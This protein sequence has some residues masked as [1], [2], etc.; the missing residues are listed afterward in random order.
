MNCPLLHVYVE[1]RMGMQKA[2]ENI[3]KI[4]IYSGIT[5]S[6]FTWLLKGSV[7]TLRSATDWRVKRVHFGLLI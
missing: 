5:L 3:H 4:K 6:K 2:V 1:A 7:P